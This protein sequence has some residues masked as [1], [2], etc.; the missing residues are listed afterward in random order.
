MSLKRLNL[1]FF[2]YIFY[3]SLRKRKKKSKTGTLLFWLLCPDSLHGFMLDHSNQIIQTM[4]LYVDGRVM[5]CP[6]ASVSS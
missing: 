1:L 2:C 3:A 4:S 6:P 5:E